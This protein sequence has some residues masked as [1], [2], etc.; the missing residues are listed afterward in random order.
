[1]SQTNQG[2]QNAAQQVHFHT[3]I[4]ELDWIHYLEGI[5]S[6]QLELYN[7]CEEKVSILATIDSILIGAAIVFIDKLKTVPNPQTVNTVNWVTFWTAIAILSPL[8]ISLG[9][10]LWRIRPKMGKQSNYGRPNHRSSNGIRH[11]SNSSTYRDLLDRLSYNEIHEDLARQIYGMNNN[12]WVDQLSIKAAVIFD[13]IGLV[14][15]IVAIIMWVV[16]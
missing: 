9:I 1:M 7:W 12:I 15:F 14:V 13:L 2:T 10:V 6:K 5:V 16:S 8:F 11:N 4:S 3:T